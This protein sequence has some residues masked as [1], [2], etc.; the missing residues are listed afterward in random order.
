MEISYDEK[1]N[2]TNIKDRNLPFSDV[3]NFDFST[4]LIWHDTRIRY[5]ELRMVAIG[6]VLKRLH[7]VCFNETQDGIRVI[8]FRKANVREIKKY[9][10]Q[11]TKN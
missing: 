6:F 4:A 3:I 2:Q 7:V 8:S 9:E 10:S 11:I 5:S 1:K